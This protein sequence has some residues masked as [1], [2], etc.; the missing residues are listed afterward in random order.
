MYVHTPASFGYEVTGMI[1]FE[2]EIC[3][4]RGFL[5]RYA[6]L[7]Q[8]TYEVQLF[9]MCKSQNFSLICEYYIGRRVF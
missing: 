1:L 9:A 6:I 4:D 2:V 3:A 7:S 5:Q 8:G